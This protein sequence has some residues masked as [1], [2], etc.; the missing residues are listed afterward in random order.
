[1]IKTTCDFCGEEIKINNGVLVKV[2]E[3]VSFTFR[4]GTE[5]V[6]SDKPEFG[7]IMVHRD[8][9]EKCVEKFLKEKYANT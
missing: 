9:C 3:N 5:H 1:M 4:G 7:N 6:K 8:V 2:K